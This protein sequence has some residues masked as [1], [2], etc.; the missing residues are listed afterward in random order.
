MWPE[1]RA[2]LSGWL[3]PRR[4]IWLIGAFL[5]QFYCAPARA[6]APLNYL[7]GAG[8]RN[9]S[10]LTWGVL[11]ISIIVVVIV[12]GLLLFATLKSWNRPASPAWKEREL[13]SRATNPVAV[14]Y[15][16]LILSTAVLLGVT[17]WTMMTLADVAAPPSKPTVSIEV[18]GHEW[19]WEIKYL[20]SDPS[21]IF[22]TANEI[23]IPVGKPVAV[24]LQSADVIHSFWVPALSG[25]TDLIPGQ[26][27]KTWILADR[28]GTF[29]GQCAEYCGLQHAHMGL[30]I[31]ATS[32]NDFE[33]WR[34]NQL[35][36]ESEKSIGS[37][38][39]NVFMQKCAVCHTVRGTRAG[40]RVG[41][42]LTHLMT[43][44]TIAA[45]TL[46]NRPGYLSGWIADPQH[47]K[48]GSKM[49]RLQIDGQQLAEVRTYLEALN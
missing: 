27:N 1:L 26:I 45:G 17:I 12:T 9:V 41:P 11:T 2:G 29:R 15:A 4:T 39:Q 18:T 21:Q 47:V 40:G 31:I 43:R 44:T 6:N 8:P 10:T 32:K 46:P 28:P 20:S 30:K 5:A 38:G 48:P 42:D 25:K 33:A 34:K 35:Q 16:G 14:V 24:R 19:W 7:F 23:H 36:S 22:T 3:S 13:V 49:P 37:A